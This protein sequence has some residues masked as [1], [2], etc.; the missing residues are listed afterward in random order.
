MDMVVHSFNPRTQE[1]EVTD[2]C[3]FKTNLVYIMSSR[4][5]IAT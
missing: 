4:T 2:L 3:E 5:A 1:A